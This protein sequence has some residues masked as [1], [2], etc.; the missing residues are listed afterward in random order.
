MTEDKVINF[1]QQEFLSIDGIGDD[2][3]I[4]A[5]NYVISKDLLIEDV[6]FRRK[7]VDSKSLAYKALHVNLSDIAA[8]GASA[9]YVMLGIAIPKNCDQYI[10]DFLRAFAQECKM[11]DV[12]LIGGD[13]TASAD[14]LFIS[15]TI[16]GK[17][18]NPKRRNTARIGDVI[19]VVGN[20]G[21]AHIGLQAFEKQLPDF[22]DFKESFLKP[23]AALKEGLWLASKV[24]AMMDISDGLL[25]D[26][27]KLCK[28][29]SLSGI[30]NIDNL[31]AT[32]NFLNAC[33]ALALDPLS[34]QLVGGEDYGLLVTIEEDLYE[35]L[36]SDFLTNFCYP[37]KKIGKIIAGN[38]E[39][40]IFDRHFE[41]KLKIFSHFGE[42]N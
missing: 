31:K 13:T 29:S 27:K 34:V 37:L 19:S 11:N 2:A 6:H 42:L 5:E 23:R 1:L 30:I 39:E 35:E 36:A 41:L 40:V 17:T 10:D 14:K 16:I 28:A 7:Y 3:A 12:V 24:S 21:Y 38:A 25:V 22:D 15:I 26:L 20:L 33:K 4:F 8:M 9:T 18:N 32:E